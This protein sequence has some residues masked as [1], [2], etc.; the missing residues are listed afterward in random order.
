[1]LNF[2]LSIFSHGAATGTRTKQNS[3]RCKES[4]RGHPARSQ[5]CSLRAPQG[6]ASL[7][8]PEPRARC[9]RT[10]QSE[11]AL[12]KEKKGALGI[13]S[14]RS[15][16][17]RHTTHSRPSAARPALPRSGAAAA[18]PRRAGITANPAPGQ[19]PAGSPLRAQRP[20]TPTAV[21]RPAA[22]NREGGKGSERCESKARFFPGHRPQSLN[23]SFVVYLFNFR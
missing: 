2:S 5:L 22:P 23:G 16:I 13:P 12:R 7:R 3:I 4:S 8:L 20:D 17:A 10:N 11:V 18:G 9:R 19:R 1:M 14:F 15:A 6:R 21:R